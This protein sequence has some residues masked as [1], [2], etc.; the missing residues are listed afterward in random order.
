[1]LVLSPPRSPVLLQLFQGVVIVMP[2]PRYN[3]TNGN[4][5]LINFLKLLPNLTYSN[6]NHAA[7]YKKD[8][9]DPSQYL[10]V[11]HKI[12]FELRYYAESSTGSKGTSV[13]E[14]VNEQGFCFT[15]I[16]NVAVFNSY[17]YVT[18]NLWDEHHEGNAVASNYLSDDEISLSDMNSG[19]EV[20]VHSPD[21]P[22][23]MTSRVATVGPSERAHVYL[24]ATAV[25]ASPEVWGLRLAQR[26]C[27][28]PWESPL[29]TT[30]VYSYAAC[31]I[32]CR[33]LLARRLCGCAPHFYKRT[34]NTPLQTCNP[35]ALA[36]LGSCARESGAINHPS[37][38]RMT[39]VIHTNI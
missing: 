22:A 2:E 27:R 36:S 17:Q 18:S 26:R 4:P 6:F 12:R 33:L 38:A 21:E 23:Q 5:E 3:R 7:K 14:T 13:M 28:F 20:Y 15:F 24:Q 35:F 10:D 9:I 19:A 31:R 8:Y 39:L 1:M 25:R 34:G 32:Y 37:L 11:I 16:S 29:P 30:P